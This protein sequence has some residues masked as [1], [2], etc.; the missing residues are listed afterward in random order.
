MHVA[1]LDLHLRLR[2]V[3]SLKE[4][5]SVIRP[6]LDRLPKLGVSVSETADHDEHQ[7]ARLGVAVVSGSPRQATEILDEAERIVW[8]RPDIEVLSAERTWME[9][10]R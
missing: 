7:Q 9:L 5:R 10:D 6:I 4:K 1:A 2:Q 8:S 3:Q